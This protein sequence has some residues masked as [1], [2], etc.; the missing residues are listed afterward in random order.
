[1]P[2]GLV[3]SNETNTKLLYD[4]ENVA[5]FPKDGI[6]RHVRLGEPSVNPEKRGTK[7]T[8]QRSSSAPMSNSPS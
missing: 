3:C 6:D 7:G 5:R 4:A 8:K 1:M 2:K